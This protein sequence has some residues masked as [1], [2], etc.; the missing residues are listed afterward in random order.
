MLFDHTG[1]DAS[2]IQAQGK[3]DVSAFLRRSDGPFRIQH[4]LK[5]DPALGL[6]FGDVINVAEG[7][8]LELVRDL[9][10]ERVGHGIQNA[11]T[12][13]TAGTVGKAHENSLDWNARPLVLYVRAAAS[14]S[15]ARMG[16]SFE[17]SPFAPPNSTRVSFSSAC[18]MRE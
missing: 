15:P 11:E 14:A 6:H 5:A 16:G 7:E 13:K 4:I 10:P 1:R 18:Y 3:N 17:R 8:L 2:H 12:G 9:G